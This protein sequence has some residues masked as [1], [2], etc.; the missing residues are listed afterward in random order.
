MS[1]V[2]ESDDFYAAGRKLA[3]HIANSKSKDLYTA[4]LQALIRDFL[5]RHEELQESLR[6]IVA[7]P[8]FLQLVKLVGSQKGLAQKCFFVENL[9]NKYS[10]GTI[11]AADRLVCGMM[12]LGEA[13]T[14]NASEAETI[15]GDSLHNQIKGS[16]PKVASLVSTACENSHIQGKSKG[17]VKNLS[18]DAPSKSIRNL[19]IISVAT[20]AAGLTWQNIVVREPETMKDPQLKLTPIDYGAIKIIPASKAN[21]DICRAAQDIRKPTSTYGENTKELTGY[22]FGRFAPP[23]DTKQSETWVKY[24]CSEIPGIY[25]W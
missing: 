11:I 5:P 25:N 14:P 17:D 16:D 3:R 18:Q 13:G 19:V 24:S 6:S 4:T 12:A 9:R 15:A 7:R 8:D 20:L 10:A 1:H 21:W 23:H 2:E 22:G